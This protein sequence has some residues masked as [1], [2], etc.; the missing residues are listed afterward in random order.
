MDIPIEEQMPD[1]LLDYACGQI[2]ALKTDSGR[3][4]D[5][6]EAMTQVGLAPQIQSAIADPAFSDILW[7]RYLHF[8]VK[9]TI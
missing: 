5:I 1:D 9:D 8:W 7:T 2:A 6:Q 3:E 4:M